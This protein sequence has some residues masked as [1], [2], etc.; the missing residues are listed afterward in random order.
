MADESEFDT[1][2]IPILGPGAGSGPATPPPRIVSV[3]LG[4]LSHQ[5]KVRL[6]NEDHYLIARSKRSI[7][8]SATNLPDSKAPPHHEEDAFL[9]IV[10]DGMGGA[11]SGEHASFRATV[12]TV[13]HALAGCEWPD[14]PGTDGRETEDRLR[15]SFAEVDR[16]LLDEAR[17]D[18]VLA[19]M[20]TTLIV[21]HSVG[22]RLLIAHAGDSR[23]YL[24][25]EGL[26]SRLTTDHTLA[27][28]L[29]DTGQIDPS[30]VATHPKRHI[31]TNYLGGP[32]RGVTAQIGRHV[33]QDGDA[34]LLCTDG[35]T[36]MVPEPTIA[37]VLREHRIPSEACDELVRQAL[38]AG[39][40]D[41]VTVVVARFRVETSS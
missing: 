35:L 31:L 13:R 16:R 23:A 12:Q 36:E 34:I 21:C 27:Q 30:E 2:E 3:E 41:N 22:D 8:L 40:T 38:G 32:S 11:A 9:M 24:F 26:L 28:M 25:R 4:G 37:A 20:G 5:G 33:L 14:L 18:P 10:A 1:A 29:A 39:G 7:D 17:S 19:G 6:N 15:S